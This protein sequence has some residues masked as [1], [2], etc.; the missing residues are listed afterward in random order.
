MRAAV[1]ESTRAAVQDSPLWLERFQLLDTA[2][3]LQAESHQH[4]ERRK[5]VGA[6]RRHPWPRTAAVRLQGATVPRRGPR[7]PRTGRHHRR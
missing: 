2:A 7:P 3:E 4:G 5:R 1:V 6:G